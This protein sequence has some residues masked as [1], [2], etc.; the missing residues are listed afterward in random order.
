MFCTWIDEKLVTL[1]KEIVVNNNNDINIVD[2][3]YA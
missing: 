2:I 3:F 1:S